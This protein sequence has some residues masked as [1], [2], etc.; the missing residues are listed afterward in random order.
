MQLCDSRW[1]LIDVS[2]EYCLHLESRNKAKPVTISR[3]KNPGSYRRLVVCLFGFLLEPV[4]WRRYLPPKCRWT[5][6]GLH[7]VT[8]QKIL[9][10]MITTMRTWNP[11][12]SFQVSDKQ[13]H[14]ARLSGKKRNTSMETDE[15]ARFPHT[16]QN[17]GVVVCRNGSFL[18][19][20]VTRLCASN[21]HIIFDLGKICL[22][23][24]FWGQRH[25]PRV[26]IILIVFG[27]QSIQH[28]CASI[29][30]KELSMNSEL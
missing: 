4:G 20:A 17:P 25:L 24:I 5:Y 10:V 7:G 2:E 27:W 12:W 14:I 18:L 19:S 16:L 29:L 26:Q 9:L 3:K 11:T 28:L 30:W 1:K 6:T 23:R 15:S 13:S 8:S 21:G 22:W